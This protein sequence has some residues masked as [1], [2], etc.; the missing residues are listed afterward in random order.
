MHW[1]WN[2]AVKEKNK[3]V[4][5]TEEKETPDYLSID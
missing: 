1:K 3:Q 5:F 2:A 4:D